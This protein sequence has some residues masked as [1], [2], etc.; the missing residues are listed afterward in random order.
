MANENLNPRTFHEGYMKRL[1]AAELEL[2][3]VEKRAKSLAEKHEDIR[4]RRIALEQELDEHN[5]AVQ[6]LQTER[7]S[8]QAEYM[9]ASFNDDGEHI[10]EIKKRRAELDKSIRQHE[11]DIRTRRSS[12]DAL[13]DTS[14]EAA[15]LHVRLEQLN[16]GN[17]YL[18]ASE[19]RNILVRHEAGL[20][21]R[22]S[23]AERALPTVD[24]D[25][26]ELV[27][28]EEIPG[29]LE[30][31]QAHQQEVERAQQERAR[32][33]QELKEKAGTPYIGAGQGGKPRASTIGA[34]SEKIRATRGQ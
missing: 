2:E 31:K 15:E 33:E 20:N 32:K 23:E 1:R 11:T 5:T 27:R 30:E 10:S 22:K 24:L 25:T 17:A 21:S 14:R 26:L 19:L 7:A 12:L 29:Y 4:T 16:Y 8:L 9:E 13:E 3:R 6:D 28:E 18:F 34:A